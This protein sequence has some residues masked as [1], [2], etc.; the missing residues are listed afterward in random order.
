MSVAN[1]N[2]THTIRTN[3]RVRDVEGLI[4]K[5]NAEVAQLPAKYVISTDSRSV[6]L[7]EVPAEEEGAD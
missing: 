4:A 5:L 7:I 3:A 1:W 6:E 2:D